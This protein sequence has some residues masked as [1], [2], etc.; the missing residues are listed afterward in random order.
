M[1]VLIF[2]LEVGDRKVYGEVF[3]NEELVGLRIIKRK[4]VD[5]MLDL[6]NGC[7][8]DYDD[9]DLDLENEGDS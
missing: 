3:M 2:V 5:I 9:D 8:G 6:E 4:R 7:F 1:K